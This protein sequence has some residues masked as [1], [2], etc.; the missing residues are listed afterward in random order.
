MKAASRIS[1]MLLIAASASTRAQNAPP[2]TDIYLAD[3]K[4]EDVDWL[5]VSKA[6]QLTDRPAY[7]NQPSFL[8]DGEA[9]LY[10]AYQS[11]GQTDILR[12]DLSGKSARNLTNTPESEYS[13]ALTPD[14][15]HFSVIRVESDGR[16]RLWKFPLQGG[17]PSLVLTDAQPVGYQVWAGS[18]SVILF[19]LGSPS[20][21]QQF[22]V[23]GGQSRLLAEGVG[24][25][26]Q[27]AKNG[28]AVAYV[29]ME[30]PDRWSIQSTHLQSGRS[31]QL[32]TTLQGSEDFVW[33][34]SGSLL[35]GKGS[36]LYQH[37]VDDASPRPWREIADL[38][39]YG[40]RGIT[41][42]AISPDGKRLALVA[43]H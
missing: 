21:L 39:E 22:E 12:L 20:T 6:V 36:K 10:T 27:M 24:R 13:P 26:L 3:L 31:F 5:S 43:E 38:S 40:V 25:S 30:S 34:P 37:R 41:R 17:E 19:I 28:S 23:P 9:I 32:A 1:V 42:L 7:D 18:D 35:M 29:H 33:T 4:I 11:D 2:A 8:A 14:G 15:Q 16:Q